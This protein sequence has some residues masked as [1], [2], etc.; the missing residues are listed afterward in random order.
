MSSSARKSFPTSGAGRGTQL[1]EERCMPSSIFATSGTKKRAHGRGSPSASRPSRTCDH[2]PEVT[3]F[4]L[5]DTGA[6]ARVAID[7][8]PRSYL[9]ALRC[10]RRSTRGVLVLATAAASRYRLR[11]LENTLT[12]L[13]LKLPQQLHRYLVATLSDD[14]TTLET[15]LP[16]V[17]P[18]TC[19][20][21]PSAAPLH[22][23]DVAV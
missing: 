21:G 14:A 18:M 11:E 8:D 19:C 3:R 13:S 9:F 10:Y 22:P 1:E 15:F 4:W 2:A 12:D 7:Y 5:P 6:F 17:H 16:Q 20:Y 23:L